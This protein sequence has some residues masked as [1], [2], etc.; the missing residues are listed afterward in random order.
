MV[1]NH[2]LPSEWMTQTGRAGR[3]I[4]LANGVK[5]RSR[6]IL[7]AHPLLPTI[8]EN[9]LKLMMKKGPSVVIIEPL[10]KA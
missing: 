10:A 7:K 8:D 1:S 4:F 3:Q 2:P 6:R 9:N 5:Y